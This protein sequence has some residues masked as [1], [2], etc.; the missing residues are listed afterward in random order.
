M[1]KHVFSRGGDRL[2]VAARGSG[3]EIFDT[4]GRRYLDGSG[5][6]IVVGIGH[7]V[8]EVADAIADQA[9]SIAY[10]HGS[11]FT[12]GSLE[13]YAEELAPLLPMDDP[14]VYPVSGGSEAVETALKM[15][16]AFHLARGEDRHVIIGRAGAYH[17][18]TRGALDVS[19]R[20]ALRAPYLPWLGAAEHTTTPYEFRCPFPDSHPDACGPRHADALDALIEQTGPGQVAAFIAEPI[21][22]AAL[23]G[24]VPPSDYWPAIAEVCRRHGVL[25]IADEVMTGFGRTGAWFGSDH[26]GLRPDLMVLAKGAASGYW[27]L[28]LAVASGHVHDELISGGFTHGFTYSHHVVGAAAGRAVLA[29]LREHDLVRASAER[30]DQLDTALRTKLGEHPSVG[31]IRGLGLLRGIELVADRRTAQPFARSERVIERVVVAGKERGVLLY[32]S[33]GCANGTDG[34]LVVLGP[35]LVVTPAQTE[36]LASLTAAAIRDV[37]G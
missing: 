37:L 13:A 35:P 5:G 23:G 29:H 9:R 28:G 12:S 24:C 22:G 4:D 8:T 1:S 21:S 3:A 31:D 11:A 6:A 27:P 32:P 25:L 18:N 14:H 26:F 36:E 2:P 20:P 17:G 10:V 15:A 30:G 19:G 7:G 34:D 16:R 33:T